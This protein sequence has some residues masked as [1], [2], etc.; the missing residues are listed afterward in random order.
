M[1]CVKCDKTLQNRPFNTCCGIIHRSDQFGEVEDDK[2][3]ELTWEVVEFEPYTADAV[4][5]AR[6]VD[7]VSLTKVIPNG[8]GYIK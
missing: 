7:I 6:P 3:V 5:W 8:F 4:K 2:D 1:K